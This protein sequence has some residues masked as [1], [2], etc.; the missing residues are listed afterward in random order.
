MIVVGTTV[1][2]LTVEEARQLPHGF[3][4]LEFDSLHETFRTVRVGIEPLR[5]EKHFVY[6]SY[7]TPPITFQG[8]RGRQSSKLARKTDW[9]VA[10]G[11]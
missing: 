8:T 3:Q 11:N 9:S 2:E 6:V 10:A 1:Y 5:D 4:L 7:K